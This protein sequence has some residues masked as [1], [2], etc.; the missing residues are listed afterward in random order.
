MQLDHWT[1]GK[2]WD[3][4]QAQSRIGSLQLHP[5]RHLAIQTKLFVSEERFQLVLTLGLAVHGCF[6]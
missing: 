1:L 5:P 3:I 2:D 4:K 6:A